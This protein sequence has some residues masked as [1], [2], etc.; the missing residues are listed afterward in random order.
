MKK[1]T[2]AIAVTALMCCAQKVNAQYYFYNDKYYETDLLFDVGVSAGGMNC[3]TDLGGKKG[4][5]KK[6]IKDLNMKNTQLSGGVYVAA[7]YKSAV[8]LRLEATFGKIKAYDSILKSEQSDPK[9]RYQRNLNFRSNI[10]EFSATAELHPLYLMLKD[11][12]EPP[13]LSPYLLG[14]VGL[15]SFRPQ[16]Q[17]NNTWVD[18]EPLRTEGQGFTEYP[19]RKRYKLTQMSIPVGVGVRYEVSSMLN[20]RFEIVHRILSTDYLDDVS[21]RYVDPALFANYLS[22]VQAAVATQMADRRAAVNPGI[23]PGTSDV[24]GDPNDNDAFFSINLKIGITLG[25]QRYR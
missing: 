18:L 3:F 5:G 1:M 23:V 12:Q 13:R 7:T 17:L 16:A 19:D 9:S 15:F 11:D 25:R 8:S 24:R 20:A 22:P 4:P 21:K 2:L 10:T 6:F 14:G